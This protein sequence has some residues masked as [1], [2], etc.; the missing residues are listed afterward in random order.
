MSS[1]SSSNTERVTERAKRIDIRKHFAREV[2]QKAQMLLVK[3]P[4]SSQ[5]E[6]T[7]TKGL[8]LP[9]VL[10][11]VDGLNLICL[12]ELCPQ[13]GVGLQ[14]YQVESR[15]PSRGVSRRSIGS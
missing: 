2:I 4:T 5:L 14:G 13:E 12:S 9:Q 1:F 7:L 15:R 3:V 6:D 10:A 8:H 11:C